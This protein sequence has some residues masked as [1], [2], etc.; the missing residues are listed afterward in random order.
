MMGANDTGDTEAECPQVDELIAAA[1]A[2]DSFACKRGCSW[3]CHQLIVM[4]NH[5]DGEA[6]LDAAE[7]RMS[8][9]QFR[10][11]AVTVRRQAREIDSMPYEEAETRTWTCPLLVNNQCLVYDVRPIACRSVFSS[12]ASCCKAMLEAERFDDLTDAQQGLATEIG[13][14]AMSLQIAANDLRP[15]DAPI[16]LRALLARLLERR[17]ER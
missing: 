7:A 14:R 1:T 5:A 15:I 16:E 10:A 4:V 2:S 13:E 6:I 12:D 17:A 3:C 8:R 11:F 9:E